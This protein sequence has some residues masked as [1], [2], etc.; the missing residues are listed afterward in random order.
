MTR[1][2]NRITIEEAVLVASMNKDSKIEKARK[3]IFRAYSDL[4]ES[5]G[6]DPAVWSR[7]FN[8]KQDPTINRIEKWAEIA[9][10]SAVEIFQAFMERRSGEEKW[11]AN[12]NY[13][14]KVKN[15]EN[16]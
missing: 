15:A 13:H 8:N 4:H 9:G 12:S 10:C 3:F 1:G 6:I 11:T 14:W 16:E 2:I 5:T 7:Y